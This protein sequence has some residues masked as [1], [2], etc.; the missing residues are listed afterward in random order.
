MHYAV[1]KYSTYYVM[2]LALLVI[3][4]VWYILGVAESDTIPI[5]H[6]SL[7]VVWKS[8]FLDSS[9]TIRTC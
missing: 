5:V 7:V 3:D 1:R 6:T 2:V 8:E 9:K 4:V